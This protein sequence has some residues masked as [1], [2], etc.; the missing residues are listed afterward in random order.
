[1]GNQVKFIVT[2]P[3]SSKPPPPSPPT[4]AI[5]DDGSPTQF[6]KRKHLS[7]LVPL[8]NTFVAVHCSEKFTFLFLRKHVDI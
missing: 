3:K 7:F 2:Q 6:E 8:F 1:M 4:L 5:N